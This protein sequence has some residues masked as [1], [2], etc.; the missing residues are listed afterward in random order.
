MN[1]QQ[2]TITM[3]VCAL[4]LISLPQPFIHVIKHFNIAKIISTSVLGYSIPI[5]KLAISAIGAFIAFLFWDYYKDPY[6]EVLGHEKSEMFYPQAH[7]E[8]Q[9]KHR[10]SVKN[11]GKGPA[12]GC[13]AYFRLE[14]EGKDKYGNRQRLVLNQPLAWY[15]KRSKFLTNQS[16]DYSAERTL[17][18]GESAYLDLFQQSKGLLRTHDWVDPSEKP[19]II[20]K[21]N[22]YYDIDDVGDSIVFFDLSNDPGVNV[23]LYRQTNKINFKQMRQ[24]EWTDSKFIIQTHEGEQVRKDCD[25]AWENKCLFIQ[26]S[27]HSGL[28]RAIYLF[29]KYTEGL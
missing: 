12:Y 24:M 3:A 28:D 7:K 29:R 15:N 10:I 8:S 23:P 20:A 19:V 21:E 17:A 16:D 1:R 18:A 4:T 2:A 13:Q 5:G 6:I 22:D 27:N 25:V 14:G 26:F 11:I 9:I